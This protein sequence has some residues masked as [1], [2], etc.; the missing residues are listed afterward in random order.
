MPCFLRDVAAR[1]LYWRGWLD[2]TI[3]RDIA[4][5]FSRKY[6]ARIC[7]RV[8]FRLAERA[9]QGQY[10][11]TG[12]LG[13]IQSRRLNLYLEAMEEVFLL[14]RIPCHLKG[15]GK[16]HWTVFDSGL[17]NFLL[18]G[19][20]SEGA[21]LSLLRVFLFNEISAMKEY[22]GQRMGLEYFKS[23]R[24]QPVDLVWD[25]IPIKIIA[26]LPKGGMGWEKRGLD[27]AMKAL[28]VK[29]GII[30]APV[31]RAEIK[32]EGISLVPWTYWS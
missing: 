16:D 29:R 2:T 1:N 28:G 25:G 10:L 30:C 8:L 15:T 6:E 17:L 24:G 18:K 26:K 9:L 14:R 20:V 21:T 7:E 5:F 31:E 19:H 3:H 12:D 11:T 22:A 4:R 13:E 32:K 27:G 23:A